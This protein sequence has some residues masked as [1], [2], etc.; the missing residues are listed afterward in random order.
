MRLRKGDETT[1]TALVVRWTPAM[2]RL[3]A[4]FVPTVQSAEEVV[5]DTWLAV[6]EGI[7]SFQGRSQLRTWV[8]SILIRKAQSAGRRERRSIPFTAAWRDE[9]SPA[10][11]PSRFR[12]GG[13]TPQAGGWLYPLPRWDLQPEDS[14]E[15]AELRSVI[16]DALADLPRR[17][18]QVV[19]VR[20]VWGC[21][22]DEACQLL[23]VTANYQR[24]LLH[25]G[26]ARLRT[27][28]EVYITQGEA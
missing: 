10:V 28:V 27:A 21:T 7:D 12:P 17:Q 18:Q 24:V 25:R 26:R 19:M 9:H 20:D 11:D 15:N 22:A 4:Q 5:Q 8:M 6:I 16:D 23:G 14:A 1:L 13:S 3:A 2:T